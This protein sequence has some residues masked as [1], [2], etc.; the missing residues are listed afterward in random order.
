MD[1]EDTLEFL[2]ESNAIEKV[3][4]ANSLF[5]AFVAWEYLI[6]Q[7]ELT[8]SVILKTHKILMLHSN[9]LPNEKGYFRNIMV[10]VGGH[11]GLNAGK[12]P[13]AI[14]SWLGDVATSIKIPGK[15]GNHIK[16]DHIT[17]EKIHPF[18]DGNGRTG[19]II[20]LW[21]RIKAGLPIEIIYEKDKENY[22]KWFK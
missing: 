6:K 10:S 5:Q 11:L 14:E 17:Y 18:V 19:R 4:D 2:K 13:E 20:M 8:A 3:Y 7:E 9:L 16:L 1:K 21:Q 12:I 15:N 22:Y